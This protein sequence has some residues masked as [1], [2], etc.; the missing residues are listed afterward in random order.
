M[1]LPTESERDE[2]RREG[3]K[4]GRE[5]R[6]GGKRMGK[7]RGHRERRRDRERKKERGEGKGKREEERIGRDRVGRR[8]RRWRWKR[9]GRKRKKV[10][11]N[12]SRATTRECS[13]GFG[14]QFSCGYVESDLQSL[15]F[16]SSVLS[17]L[18]AGQVHQA[19]LTHLQTMPY[20]ETLVTFPFYFQPSSMWLPVTL[21]PRSQTTGLGMG[22]YTYWM[23]DACYKAYFFSN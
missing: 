17:S 13:L 21:N 4:E 5:E 6:R 1:L 19:D 18:T 8:K 11:T 3:R 22:I 20:M 15:S 23:G 12:P 16:G 9:R 2:K 10:H 14:I 7:K